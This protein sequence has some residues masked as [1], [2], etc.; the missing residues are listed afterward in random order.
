MELIRQ[1]AEAVLFID[2][3]LGKKVVRKRRVVKRY[4][5]AALDTALRTFRTKKEAR[6]IT[7]ARKVG[8][9][10]PVIYDVDLSRAEMVM[11]YIPGQLVKDVLNLLEKTKRRELCSQIGRYIGMLHSHDIVHGDLTTSN[12]ILKEGIVYFI[13]FSLGEKTHEI[14]AKGVDLHLLK[15]VWQSTHYEYMDGYRTL[16]R[17]YC[18][19]Y[20]DGES[21]LSK[22]TEIEKRGRYT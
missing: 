12:M 22:I 4:R 10:T 16:L 8:I 7:E 3:W 20:E 13:D 9:P 11:E 15:E 21:V 2:T 6:L 5:D 14:E 19:E 18:D 17:A 1:G